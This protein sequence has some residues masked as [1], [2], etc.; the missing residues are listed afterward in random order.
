VALSTALVLLCIASALQLDLRSK[1]QV[2][3]SMLSRLK[4]HPMVPRCL[5]YKLSS[6]SCGLSV[7]RRASCIFKTACC[8]FPDISLG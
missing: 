3:V 5:K 6:T 7:E 1:R 4:K 8:I 2:A